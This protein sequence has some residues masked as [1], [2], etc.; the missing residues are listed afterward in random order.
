MSLFSIWFRS[1]M[2]SS[3]PA[4]WRIKGVLCWIEVPSHTSRGPS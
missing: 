3:I 1:I 4:Q 2:I